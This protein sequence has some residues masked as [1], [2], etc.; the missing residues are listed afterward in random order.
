MA[1]LFAI[2]GQ[3]QIRLPVLQSATGESIHNRIVFKLKKF[4]LPYLR[5]QQR[6]IGKAQF[7]IAMYYG[8]W[9]NGRKR[10]LETDK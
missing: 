7:A 9:S 1:A 3:F 5:K 8:Y 6:N 2:S 10:P 4:Y